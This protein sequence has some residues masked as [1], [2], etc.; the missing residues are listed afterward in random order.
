M[1]VVHLS[2][3][4]SPFAKTGGLG[5]VVGALPK[6]QAE[7]G[8]QVQVWMPYYRAARDYLRTRNLQPHWVMDP[9]QVDVGFQRWQAGILRV[10]LPG[11]AVPVFMVGLDELFDRKHVYSPAPDGRDDGILRYSVFTRVVLEALRRMGTPPDVL[12]CH[13]WHTTPALMALAWDRPRDGFFARTGTVLTIH[14]LAYQGIYSPQ[15]FTW[16]GFPAQS[17]GG[18]TWDGALNLMKGGIVSAGA[19]TAVS[20][21]FADEIRSEDGGFHLDGMLRARG[22]A[23]VGIL[24]GV[25]TRVWNPRTDGRIPANYDADN[26]SPKL[27]NRRALLALAGMDKEDRGLVVGVVSRLTRQKGLDLLFPVLPELLGDGIR[28]VCLGSGDDDQERD[29]AYWGSAAPGRFFGY[30][31]FSDELAHLIEAGVDAFLMPS[32]F[33]PCGLSQMY[34]LLYGAV[35]IVRR[36]GGLADTV[37]G[38]HGGGNVMNANGFTFDEASPQALRETVRWAHRCYRDPVLWT[39]LMRNGMTEDHS[40]ARS[41]ARYTAVYNAVRPR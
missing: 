17:A 30:V 18:V 27:E 41:S 23:V 28:F 4:V 32:R 15:M 19:I 2:A 1:R 26:L 11:S 5:D 29:L 6:A 33:E 8:H 25:D 24:N 21:T 7:E 35:P 40:W 22:A 16:L 3:E 37:R 20:P 12:H 14:N 10:D 39:R 31:G 38:F 9:I 34:S 13:D 36:V